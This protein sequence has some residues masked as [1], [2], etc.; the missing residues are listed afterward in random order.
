[1]ADIPT[2]TRSKQ[3]GFF[4]EVTYPKMTDSAKKWIAVKYLLIPYV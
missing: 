4:V 2:S 3:A 1:M